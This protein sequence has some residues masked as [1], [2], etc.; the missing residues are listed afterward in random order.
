MRIQ[1]SLVWMQSFLIV[2]L[3]QSAYE[4]IHYFRCFRCVVINIA[5]KH[6]LFVNVFKGLLWDCVVAFNI[7][8]IQFINILI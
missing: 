3:M 7:R 5:I 8:K 1:P 4:E 2:R 6:S